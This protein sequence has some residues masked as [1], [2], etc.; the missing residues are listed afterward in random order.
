MLTPD[1]YATKFRD[2]LP[3]DRY[4]ATGK[5]NEKSNWEAFHAR[6]KITDAQRSLIA[7]FQRRINVLV[8]SGT[9]CGDCVQQCPMLD[10]IARAHPANTKEQDSPGIDLRFVDRDKNLDLAKQLMI[11]GGLRVPTVIFL[12]EEF[13]FVSILGDRTISRYRA[14][15]A[16][17]LG[18][19][20]PLPG[21]PVQTDEIGATLQDWV[22]E[23]ER[24]SL[25]LLMSPKLSEK[26]A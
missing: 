3:Y 17:Y 8:I 5:P 12:N 13:E 26:H 9:W 15:A 6:V 25:L 24:V 2:A 11:C 19:A 7:G 20:C 22:N 23:F 1:F 14:L 4:V 16:K 10:H 21:A 18:A